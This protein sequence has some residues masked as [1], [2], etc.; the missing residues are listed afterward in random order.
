M[1][2]QMG[3][4]ESQQ[5]GRATV[6]P[7]YACHNRGV[8]PIRNSAKGNV[9]VALGSPVGTNGRDE[10]QYLLMP[11]QKVREFLV[12]CAVA[13]T[14]TCR[15]SCILLCCQK[16]LVQMGNYFSATCL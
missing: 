4:I 12:R 15:P 2:A 7:L 8:N 3:L 16:H 5:E 13:A 10:S 11:Y 6:H 14:G 9:M 1:R